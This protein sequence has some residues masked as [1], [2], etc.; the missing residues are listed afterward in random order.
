[1]PGVN[2]YRRGLTVSCKPDGDTMIKAF[3]GEYRWLS[4][5]WPS[6]VRW[7]GISFDSVENAYQAAKCENSADMPQFLG[8]TA[9]QSKR[10]GRKVKMRWN[11]ESV[12][13]SIM[14]DLVCQKF[15]IPE[16]KAKLLATGTQKLVEGN[17]WG[18]TFWGQCPFGTGFNH[19]G[20][21]IMKVRDELSEVQQSKT[22][23]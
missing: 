2:S 3:T 9:G 17:Y 15:N 19:L 1:M 21:I 22:E 11:W 5:F 16:L 4:N 14:E 23:H 10:L 13:L 8:L 20:I 12:K 18:D 7:Y 6:E